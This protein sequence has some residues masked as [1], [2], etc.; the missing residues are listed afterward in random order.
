MLRVKLASVFPKKQPG[1]LLFPLAQEQIG[2]TSDIHSLPASFLYNQDSRTPRGGGS[3]TRAGG[4]HGLQCSRCSARNATPATPHAGTATGT[5]A[6][7]V[8][9]Q[10]LQA[11]SAWL[12]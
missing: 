3:G 5:T 9:V 4:S 1:A 7:S 12:Q 6:G 11:G 8:S 2:H 10:L